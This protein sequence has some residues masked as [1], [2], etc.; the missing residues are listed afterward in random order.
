MKNKLLCAILIGVLVLSFLAFAE[1]KQ[2]KCPTCHGVGTIDCPTCNGT[3]E[4]SESTTRTCENCTGTGLLTPRVYAKTWVASTHDGST[5]VTA[6]F[7]NKESIPADGKAT[8]TL[9][10]HSMTTETLTFPP[11]QDLSQE[12][13]IPYASTL[14]GMQLMSALKVNVTGLQQVT[15]PYC[16]GDGTLSSIKTC[17]QC[18]GTGS[19]KCVD[20]AG[21]GYVDEAIAAQLQSGNQSS[22]PDIA[23]ITGA[24]AGVAIALG[25]GFAGFILLKKRRVN[26]KTLRRL[27]SAE[28]QAWVLKR[29]DGRSAAAA[30]NAMGIDGFTSLNQPVQIK[31]ADSVGMNVVDL[32]ASSVARK[33]TSG[34]VIVAFSYADDAIRGKVRA[35][36]NL[37]LDIQ[38]YTVAELI[39]NRKLY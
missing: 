4:V 27:S 19:V 39:E 34:G 9:Q 28:F 15:C 25:G 21:T 1:A 2:V 11:N 8:A 18:S 29:L 38:M 33:K 37:N 13:V 23:L 36:R 31:Q 22:A 16:N 32:F 17:A 14:S 10:G 12:I 26:E 30:D 7:F 5:F 6:T 3:G 24:V 20:C 35:R